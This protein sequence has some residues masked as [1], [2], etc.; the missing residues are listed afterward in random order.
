LSFSG[1]KVPA[2]LIAGL[3]KKDNPILAKAC[4]ELQSEYDAE[5]K[6]KMMSMSKEEQ[7]HIA[8]CEKNKKNTEN[9]WRLKIMRRAQTCQK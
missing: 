5:N 2:G 6:N 3:R 9:M 8:W 7:E 4:D 1:N